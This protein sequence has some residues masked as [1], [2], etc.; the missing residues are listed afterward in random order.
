MEK[1][2]NSINN[3]KNKISIFYNA[4]SVIP[5]C[6]NISMKNVLHFIE[7]GTFEDIVNEFLLE[8]IRH[9]N[10]DS[11]NN[12][13]SKSINNYNLIAKKPLDV[14]DTEDRIKKFNTKVLNNKNYLYEKIMKVRSLKNSNVEEY[15]KEKTF[16]IPAYTPHGVFEYR[17][18]NAIEQFSNYIYF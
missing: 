9:L 10:N 7:Y 2:Y 3:L 8:E 16:G 13:I 14:F 17:N 1:Q 4:M 12:R 5:I 18:N 11:V 6:N 15:Q